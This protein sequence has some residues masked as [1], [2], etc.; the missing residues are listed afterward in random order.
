[1][2]FFDKL[3]DIAK[4][5]GDKTGDAIETT[6]LSSKISSESKEIAK[7]QQK[8]GEFYY[9]KYKDGE[10]LGDEMTAI[11]VEI[12]AHNTTISEAQAE[13]NRI[14]S[15]NES[16]KPPSSSVP[17]S[18]LNFP[19]P[20]CGTI[21]DTTKKFCSGC[22]TKIEIVIPQEKVCSACG[23]KITDGL[24]FCGECGNKAE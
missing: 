4:N 18:E 22:G 21:N 7:L 16:I 17:V 2:A 6:K 13:I 19:C 5:I 24:K 23:A 9:S 8:I 14:K 1:M 11:C 3:N 10:A 15:A 12:D 20:N